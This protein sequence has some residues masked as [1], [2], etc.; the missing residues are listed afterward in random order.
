VTPDDLRAPAFDRRRA[1]GYRGPDGVFLLLV[2]PERP[3]VSGLS[4]VDSEDPL[5]IRLED[6]F[7][8]QLVVVLAALK[9]WVELEEGSGHSSPS[10]RFRSTVDHIRSSRITKKL[11]T[12][13]S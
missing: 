9:G 11:L 10:A 4:L 2:K 12:Y 13:S 3:P 1:P 6:A 5:A 8:D 7:R